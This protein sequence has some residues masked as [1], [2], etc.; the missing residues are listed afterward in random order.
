MNQDIKELIQEYQLD[1]PN[2]KREYTYKRYFLM[3]VA[4]SRGNM[5]KTSIGEMFNRD[6]S[7]VIHGIKQHKIWWKI[8]DMEYLRGI[9]PLEQ[10]LDIEAERVSKKYIYDCIC[11]E[12]TLT[13]QGKFSKRMIEKLNGKYN[14]KDISLIFALT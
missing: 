13:I 11:N 3:A 4:D 5:T 9:H 2:R 8:R 12:T 7:S 10:T 1:K 14:R 6:H